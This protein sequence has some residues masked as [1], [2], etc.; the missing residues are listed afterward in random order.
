AS[1]FQR[2]GDPGRSRRQ[3]VRHR[4]GAGGHEGVPR[5]AQAKVGRLMFSKILIANRG[6]IACRVIKT[7]R[8]LGIRTV[9]VYSDADANS[10]HVAMADEAVHIGGSAARDSYLVVDRILEAATR[11]GA[12]AVHPGYGFLSENAGFAESCGKAGIVFIGP[13]PSAIR[14]M[15]SKSER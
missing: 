13:P 3:P 2:R 10:R 1:R 5:Q 8:R 15:G 12:Q 14:A 9:A 7:A 4:R 6:D 11:M